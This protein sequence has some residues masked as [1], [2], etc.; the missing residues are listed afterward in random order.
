MTWTD[1]YTDTMDI[2]RTV[3]TTQNNLTRNIREKVASAVPCRIYRKDS[4]SPVMNQTAAQLQQTSCLACG[5]DVD[6]RTGDELLLHRGAKLGHQTQEI[7]AFAGEP[8]PYYEPFG[9]V[10]PGLAHQELL[11]L[12]Q[13]YIS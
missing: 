6:I 4:K 5:V 10:I 1:W 8:N 13:E 7:R 12:Q 2:Y 9:A 11:L 3:K